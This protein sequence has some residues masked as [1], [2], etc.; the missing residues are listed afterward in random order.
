MTIDELIAAMQAI[1]DSAMASEGDGASASERP[2]TEE[3]AARYE[4]LERQLMTARKSDE[5]QKRQAAYRTAAP[6]AMFGV[7]EAA[8]DEVHTRAFNAFL[9]TGTFDRDTVQFRAQSEAI[10]SAGGFLVP[11]GFR[12]MI[13]ERRVQFGGLGNE[14]ESLSTAMGNPLPWIV[15]DDTSAANAE[16]TPESGLWDTGADLVFATRSLGAYKYTTVGASQLPL[17]VSY[18]LL[19]DSAFDLP[20]W[21]ARK[22]GERIARKQAVDWVNG[23][24]VGEPVGILNAGLTNTAGIASAAPGPTYAELLAIVH[25]LDP[26]YR[27]GAKWLMNDATLAKIQGRVDTTGRPLLWNQDGSLAAGLTGQMLLGFPVVIDQAMPNTANGV[28]SIVFGN[29]RDTYVIRRVK[30]FALVVLNELF[31]QN[32]QVGYMG[33]ERADG[34]VQDPFAA[35]TVSSAGA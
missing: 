1:L 13:V 31:A 21:I 23:S 7:T 14:A 10:G 34:M 27:E 15:N 8:N 29:L 18:E 24:G 5:I 26:A 33:W 28:K 25:A 4:D 35:I 20:S 22:F 17:K 11:N 12:D 16:I 32:G 3:E 6:K 9:R 30:D 19:Q 2:L